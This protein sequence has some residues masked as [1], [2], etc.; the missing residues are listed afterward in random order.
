MLTATKNNIM[1]IWYK[2]SAIYDYEPA[3]SIQYGDIYLCIS[4]G[5]VVLA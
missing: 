4:S 5:T 3:E 1:S 2:V